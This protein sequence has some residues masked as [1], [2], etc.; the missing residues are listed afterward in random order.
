MVNYLEQYIPN[1]SQISYPLCNLPKKGISC[2]WSHKHFK[3][4]KEIQTILTAELVLSFLTPNA[5]LKSKLMLAV[6]V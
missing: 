2:H 5:Q 3:V 6:M 4:L 1:L